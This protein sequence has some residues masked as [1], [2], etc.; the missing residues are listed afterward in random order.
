MGWLK[1]IERTIEMD[2]LLLGIN[3]DDLS[4]LS[5]EV[6]D[7][8]DRIAEIFDRIDAC[9][10]KLPI[11]YQGEPC[12]IIMNKYKELT[13]YYETI[14][15]NIRSYSDDFIALIRHMQD[16]DKKFASIVYGYAD[17]TKVKTKSIDN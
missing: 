9:M 15:D 11:Y 2:D 16:N 10:D 8:A 6:L 1:C 12:D 4:S 3:E 7:Y 13:P 17:D 14:K 5:L